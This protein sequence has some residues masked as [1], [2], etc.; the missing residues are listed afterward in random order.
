MMSH[1]CSIRIL[2]IMS[3]RLKKPHHKNTNLP[4]DEHNLE[5][6]VGGFLDANM[7]GRTT[8]YTLA[9]ES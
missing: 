8:N 4:Y 1:F 5:I 9:K 6:D 7:E 2:E 3:F